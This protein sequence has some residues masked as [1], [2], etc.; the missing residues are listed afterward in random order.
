MIVT[1]ELKLKSNIRTRC[2]RIIATLNSPYEQ[3]TV[4]QLI[5]ETLDLI[6]VK[7]E[8]NA[9]VKEDIHFEYPYYPGLDAGEY[10]TYIFYSL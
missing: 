10:C 5:K 2:A 9:D 3:Q 6:G 4:E 8:H 1:E 7:R